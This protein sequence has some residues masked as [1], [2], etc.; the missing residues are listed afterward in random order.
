MKIY[1][2]EGMLLGR[3]ASVVAKELLLGE[4]V[5]IVNC[6]KILVS[7]HREKVLA[8]EKQKRERKGYPLKSAN[9]SRLPDRFVRRAVRGMLPWKKPRGKEVFENLMC[10]MGV[11][12]EFND[13]ELITVKMASVNKL[14]TLK[15]VVIGDICQSL[16]W[17]GLNGINK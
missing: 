17:K 9:F 5:N 7:G 8:N 12:D 13:K 6:E 1:N 2:G 11:P 16:G 14:P 15:Y 4:T 3:L 10:Y